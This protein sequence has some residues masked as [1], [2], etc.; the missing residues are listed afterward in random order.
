MSKAFSVPCVWTKEA[1]MYRPYASPTPTKPSGQGIYFVKSHTK[2]EPK[3]PS[4]PCQ[5]TPEC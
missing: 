3:T 5:Q 2:H 4:L 1:T